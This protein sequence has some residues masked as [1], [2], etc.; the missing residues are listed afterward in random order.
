MKKIENLINIFSHIISSTVLDDSVI[1]EAENILSETIESNRVV[2][3]YNHV[4]S[5]Y[6]C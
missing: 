1:P 5:R 3:H 2:E 6:N 4:E